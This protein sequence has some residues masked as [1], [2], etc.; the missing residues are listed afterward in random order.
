M[1]FS[2]PARDKWSTTGAFGPSS[3]TLEQDLAV[4]A[5]ERYIARYP[6]LCGF[7]GQRLKLTSQ[8]FQL[9]AEAA[10][11]LPGLALGQPAAKGTG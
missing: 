6:L 1:F 11:S 2:Y 9:G 4:S 5:F 3:L 8:G 10:P 7:Q